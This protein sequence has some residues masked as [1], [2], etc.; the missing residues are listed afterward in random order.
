MFVL[1]LTG[2]IGA[3]K[4]TAAGFFARHA[5]PVHD[6]DA[7]VHALYA[8]AGGAVPAVTALFPTA[9]DPVTG[10]VDRAA[11]SAAV[12]GKPDALAALEAAVH[13]L[14]EAERR[15]WCAARAAAGTPLVV[16]DI[17]L[18]FE[19]GAD[20]PDAGVCDAVAVVTCRDVALQRARVLTRRGSGGAA[21]SPAKLD[22]I[23]ARQ[24][25]DAEKVRRA[26]YV[27]DTSGS[28]E[29]TEAQVVEV[30]ERV[31]GRA[32]GRARW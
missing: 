5:V 22:A 25:P 32:G 10:G 15:A 12:V 23:L 6:A 2:G 27:I 19:T 16:L 14:V 24:L 31:R 18:L 17:P 8:P 3:G 9:R 30:I 1:G 20:A 4:T 28:L 26:D 13:P 21:M 7:A 11:L 29:E